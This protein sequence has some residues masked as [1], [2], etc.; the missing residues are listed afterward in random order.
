VAL[1]QGRLK[2]KPASGF[3]GYGDMQ[4]VPIFYFGE[5]LFLLGTPK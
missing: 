2:L 5:F 3:C 1:G 4:A